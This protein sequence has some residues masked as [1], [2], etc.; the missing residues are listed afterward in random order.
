M[1]TEVLTSGSRGPGRRQTGGERAPGRWTVRRERQA[2]VQRTAAHRA[3][4]DHVQGPRYSVEREPCG[5]FA[6]A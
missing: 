4:V 3:A 1:T 6:A 2:Q 5:G